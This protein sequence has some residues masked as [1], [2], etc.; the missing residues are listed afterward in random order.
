M[1][2][3]IL[4]SVDEGQML[5]HISHKLNLTANNV[6]SFPVSPLV[7]DLSSDQTTQ[8]WALVIIHDWFLFDGHDINSFVEIASDV[9]GLFLQMVLCIPHQLIFHVINPFHC[10]L[11]NSFSIGLRLRIFSHLKS[12]N[13]VWN[14]VWILWIGCHQMAPVFLFLRISLNA[15]K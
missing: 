4:F 7:P 9:Y 14:G 8:F 3:L 5:S 2:P 1:K 15:D 10:R 11:W 6:P 12:S 13:Y